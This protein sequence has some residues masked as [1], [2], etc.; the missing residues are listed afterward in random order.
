MKKSI[1]MFLATFVLLA[2]STIA[3]AAEEWEYSIYSMNIAKYFKE[4]EEENLKKLDIEH[5]GANVLL[6]AVHE[7]MMVFGAETLNVAGKEGWELVSVSPFQG[8][9][10]IFYLKRRK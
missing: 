5:P 3:S 2:G 9:R 10:V 1:F 6:T 7:K 8:Y 4:N